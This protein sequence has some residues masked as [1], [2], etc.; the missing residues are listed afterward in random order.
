VCAFVL[1]INLGLNARFRQSASAKRF[2]TCALVP[3]ALRIV[4]LICWR[5]QLVGL[6]MK[7]GR[8]RFSVTRLRQRV[9]GDRQ[10]TCFGIDVDPGVDD[11]ASKV[12]GPRDCV[13]DDRQTVW[14]VLVRAGEVDAA[15]HVERFGPRAHAHFRAA[16]SRGFG[17][18]A[19]AREPFGTDGY[20]REHRRDARWRL[21]L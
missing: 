1:A 6:T 18:L 11:D 20:A 16:H 2:G 7:W 3:C 21:D 13:G 4:A 8:L 14:G 19:C 15:R 5:S 17:A 9:A 10:R 12:Q